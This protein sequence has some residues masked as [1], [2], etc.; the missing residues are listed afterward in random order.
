M[1]RRILLPLTIRAREGLAVRVDV[2]KHITKS[3]THAIR[4]AL[5]PASIV[6]LVLSLIVIMRDKKVI[7]FLKRVIVMGV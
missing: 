1:I 6:R 4:T 2:G 3:F 5:V 7:I